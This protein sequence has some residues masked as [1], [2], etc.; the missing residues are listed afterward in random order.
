MVGVGVN[1]DELVEHV[2]VSF[3]RDPEG[4]NT[5]DEQRQYVRGEITSRLSRDTLV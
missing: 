4:M 2:E 1:H 5:T 3:G